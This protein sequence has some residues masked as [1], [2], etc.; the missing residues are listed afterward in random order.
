MPYSLITA[1]VGH[2]DNSTHIIASTVHG[3]LAHDP[4]TFHLS[5]IDGTICGNMGTKDPLL[6]FPTVIHCGQT[7]GSK[8]D[9][10]VMLAGYGLPAMGHG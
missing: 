3:G 8:T 1:S 9:F 6:L 10:A 7:V 4:I 5:A 2:N